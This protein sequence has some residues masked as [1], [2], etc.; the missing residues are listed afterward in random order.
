MLAIRPAK[1]PVGATRH[2]WPADS[3]NKRGPKSAR[4]HDFLALQ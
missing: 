2:S 1:P 4:K 3:F